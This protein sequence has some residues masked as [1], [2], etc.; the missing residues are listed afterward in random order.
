M[1][2]VK[3]LALLENK[4]H[5]AESSAD[6]RNLTIRKKRNHRRNKIGKIGRGRVLQTGSTDIFKKGQ[7]RADIHRFSLNKL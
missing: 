7:I 1:Q 3:K 6:G 5:G 2:T 4:H